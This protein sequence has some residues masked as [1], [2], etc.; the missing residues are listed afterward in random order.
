MLMLCTSLL[1]AQH[2]EQTNYPDPDLNIQKRIEEW[3]DLFNGTDLTGWDIKCH[4]TDKNK[5]F[6]NVNNSTI[7]CNSIDR[8]DHDYIWLMYEEEFSDF[9]LHLKFQV[10]KSSK[11]NSGIQFRS[12]YDESET[13][14]DGGWLNGPQVD[15]HPPNPIRTGLIYDETDGINRWIHPSLPNWEIEKKDVPK[16]ALQT[17]LVYAD[18]DPDAWNTMEII[19]E[20]LKIVTFVNDH[21][22]TNFDASGIL[23]DAIH[24]QHNVGI[25]GKIALQLHRADELFIRYKDIRI[26]TL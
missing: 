8:P 14:R 2:E 15:I 10:F 20:G 25:S 6:W 16:G 1:F 18:A 5:K 23:D 12:R 26:K 9:E 13:A 22:V 19:C 7:E 4:K 24:K 3:Q 21:R 17:E 11:G